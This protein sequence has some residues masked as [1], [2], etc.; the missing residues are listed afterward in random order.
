MQPTSYIV[1]FAARTLVAASH[2]HVYMIINK[3]HMTKLGVAVP[4]EAKEDSGFDLTTKQNALEVWLVLH[5]PR[6]NGLSIISFL[7]IR[8]AKILYELAL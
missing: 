4:K 1:V 8:P 6:R 5:V 3:N 2:N 7:H